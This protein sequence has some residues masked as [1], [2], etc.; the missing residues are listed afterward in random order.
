MP[1][2]NIL[3]HLDGHRYKYDASFEEVVYPDRTYGQYDAGAI[4][5]IQSIDK[6]IFVNQ[7]GDIFEHGTANKIGICPE[8]QDNYL[9]IKET[10]E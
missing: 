4:Y 7:A 1:E 9:S 3:V 8:I 2:P 10:G 5:W 6:V